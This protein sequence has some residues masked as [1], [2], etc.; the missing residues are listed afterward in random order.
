MPFSLAGQASVAVDR[1][2]ELRHG[3]QSHRLARVLLLDTYLTS[4][5]SRWRKE[6]Y[7][8]SEGPLQRKA[9]AKTPL[10]DV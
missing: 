4:T 8:T 7:G 5:L 6:G 2:S 10:L 3:R 1:R 9:E